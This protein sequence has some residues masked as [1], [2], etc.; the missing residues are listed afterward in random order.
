MFFSAQCPAMSE[1]ETVLIGRLEKVK[2]RVIARIPNKMR[3]EQRL[4]DFFTKTPPLIKI[5]KILYFSLE[6][7]Q[8]TGLED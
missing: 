4:T 5:S 6:R 2:H 8:D 3:R 7:S 1:A